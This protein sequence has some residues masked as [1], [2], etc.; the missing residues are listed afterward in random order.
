MSGINPADANPDLSNPDYIA[1]TNEP[2]LLTQTGVL[3]GVTAFIVVLRCYVR[4]VMLRCFGKDDWT[5]LLAFGF[6][7][8]TFIVYAEQT[9]LGLGKH[10]SVIRM[11]PG[12]ER[13]FLK[14]RQVQSILVGIGVGLVKISIAFFL[15]RLVTRKAL[16]WNIGELENGDIW[17]CIP[18]AATWDLRLRPPPIGTGTAVCF[19][20]PTFTAIGMMNTAVTISTDFLLALLLVPLVWQLQLNGRTKITLVCI[21]ALGLFAGIAAIIKSEKQKTAL[22]DPDPYVHDTFTMWRFIE[23]DVGII[24]ASLP[25]LKPL[26][27]HILNNG[28]RGTTANSGHQ[29]VKKVRYSIRTK[30]VDDDEIPLENHAGVGNSCEVSSGMPRT[31]VDGRSSVESARPVQSNAIFVDTK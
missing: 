20:R 6:A 8:A 25:S 9:K 2:L 1:Y 13:Q 3:F 27:K 11:N 24:V 10:L 19:D 28:T 17:Q 18:V 26:F 29:V 12:N 16:Y 5:M 30:I 22:T 15:L 21:L 14:L 23:Y 31:P 7:M 4:V